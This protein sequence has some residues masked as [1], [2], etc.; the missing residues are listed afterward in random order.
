MRVC[1]DSICRLAQWLSVKEG[2]AM[3]DSGFVAPVPCKLPKHAVHTLAE[4]VAKKL[5][6]QPGGDLFELLKRLGGRFSYQE[7]SGFGETDSGSLIVYGEGDFEINIATNTSLVRD[8]FTIAHEIGHYVLHYLWPRQNSRQI[9][10]KMI[11]ARYGSDRSEWEA[12][13]FAA[14]FLMPEKEFKSFFLESDK[15]IIATAEYFG[16]STK[17]AR[18][19]SEALELV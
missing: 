13:W 3:L 7:F 6:F 15:N 18:V 8:R 5:N 11:A 17:A 9:S 12:N 16:V 4:N 2:E 1:T 19:R 10:D 14:A